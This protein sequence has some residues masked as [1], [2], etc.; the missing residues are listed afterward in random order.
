MSKKCFITSDQGQELLKLLTEQESVSKIVCLNRRPMNVSP[1]G[2]RAESVVSFMLSV[3]QLND[4]TLSVA[5]P[6]R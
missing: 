6:L 5:V 4:I 2:A 1:S 3:V